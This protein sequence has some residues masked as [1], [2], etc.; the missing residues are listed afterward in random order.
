M[1]RYGLGYPSEVATPG[2]MH[3]VATAYGRAAWIYERARPDYPVELLTRLNGIYTLTRDTAV[4]DVGA[5][6]GKLSRL[7]VKARC[8]VTAVEPSAEMRAVLVKEVPDVTAIDGTAE[9]IPLGERCADV[10]VAGEAFHWFEPVKA[11]KELTRVL[12]PGGVVLAAWLHRNVA[13]WQYQLLEYLHPYAC[14]IPIADGPTNRS[15]HGLPR[16]EFTDP[17]HW[18]LI[19]EQPYTMSR[20]RQ[21]Y[22]SYSYI[23]ALDDGERV[24]VLDRIEGIVRNELKIVDDQTFPL[25]L[26]LQTW[27][28]SRL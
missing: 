27:S 11:W 19:F 14:A 8:D 16:G 12:R 5:G 2:S 10:V 1:R 3:P 15:L 6:T 20:L 13:D 23:S 4:L 18:S 9:A 25:P 21:M 24:N 7:L 26:K 17:E 28:T 22:E